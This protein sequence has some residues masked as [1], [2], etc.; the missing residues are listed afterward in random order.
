M[1]EL[2]DTNVFE[3]LNLTQTYVREIIR[4]ELGFNQ[5][6]KVELINKNLNI[7]LKNGQSFVIPMEEPFI[8]EYSS[9]LM[10]LVGNLNNNNIANAYVNSE[11]LLTVILDNGLKITSDFSYL[12]ENINK[13]TGNLTDLTTEVK[14]SLVASINEIINKTKDILALY[15]KN[16]EA[17]AGANGWTDLL[18]QTQNGRTQAEKNADSVSVKD[19]GAKGD[20]IKD[21]TIALRNAFTMSNSQNVK[22]PAGTYLVSSMITLADNPKHLEFDAGAIIKRN[23]D[24]AAVILVTGNGWKISGGEFDGNK[25]IFKNAANAGIFI[26]GNKN[27]VDNCK[28]HDNAS[29]GI[30][31]DGAGG[32]GTDNTVNNCIVK[33]CDAV[34][35]SQYKAVSS[36]IT[37]NRVYNAG[38][39]GITVDLTNR[40]RVIGNV[41]DGA[42][43]IGAVGGMGVD[44]AFENTIA[45]NLIVGT[46]NKLPA[47]TLESQAGNT[48]HNTVM[49]NN[50][51][52]NEGHGIWV[53]HRDI[54]FNASNNSFYATPPANTYGH[55]DWNAITGNNIRG[56]PSGFYPIRVDKNCVG[57]VLSGNVY[58]G[59]L[60]SIDP[61]S[62]DT[63]SDAGLTAFMANNTVWQSN[64]TGDNSEH[65]VKFNNTIFDRGMCYD[66]SSGVF[67]V[68]VNG[69]YQFSASVRT[70]GGSN[71]DY[72]ILSIVTSNGTFSNGV[73]A[74]DQSVQMTNISAVV[75]MA[76]GD[77]AKVIVRVGGG[78][79]VVSV[80]ADPNHTWFNGSLIG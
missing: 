26:T 12:N 69:V 36:S 62:I 80:E 48:H 56:V 6:T 63:R 65:Q 43:R 45:G 70:V 5:I 10:S 15:D 75:Y 19:F 27:T 24:G 60:P 11:G 16:V 9:A 67:T 38:A 52:D 57:N 13:I 51:L 8:N 64:I 41:I 21:D 73:A 28:V 25:S 53:R 50:L 55:G 78:D 33:D 17:G 4:A 37:N 7:Y 42:A 40:S 3:N 29:H 68:P 54:I 47:I 35:I 39:E 71:H 72:Q 18:V 2:N 1:P 46:K 14:T 44:A 34:G 23:F 31:I 49:G 32:G 77:T 74:T 22:I 30:S 59:K 79:K 58:D 61:A 20:G 66:N 76:S